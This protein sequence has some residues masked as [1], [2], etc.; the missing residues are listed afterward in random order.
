MAAYQTFTYPPSHLELY[1]IGRNSKNRNL[2]GTLYGCGL[3][4]IFSIIINFWNETS[5]G[6]IGGL[7]LAAVLNKNCSILID[8]YEAKPVISTIG[9]GIAIWKRSWQVLQDLG[10]EEEIAKRK[11]PLPKEGEGMCYFRAERTES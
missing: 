10:L 5:G 4:S 3:Y 1:V 6:G 2:V 7:T 11:L 9:A 8:I